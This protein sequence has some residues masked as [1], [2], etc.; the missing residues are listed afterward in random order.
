[1]HK[2]DFILPHLKHIRYV[3]G[4]KG[5]RNVLCYELRWR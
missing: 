4:V 5:L 3:S 1:M 2:Q